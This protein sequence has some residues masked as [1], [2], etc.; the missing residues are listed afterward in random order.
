LIFNFTIMPQNVSV[1]ISPWLTVR[2]S[3]K[4]VKFYTEAF[5]AVEVYRME[6]PDGEAVVRLSVSGAEFWLSDGDKDNA[7]AEQIGGGTIRIILTISDPEKIFAQALAA[8]ATEIF[9]VG[10]EHGWKLGRLA[11]PFGLHWEIGHQ[12]E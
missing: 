1:S 7:N 8:G 10:E 12:V 5:D 4:A 6:S 11:D 2:S 9:P 3:A